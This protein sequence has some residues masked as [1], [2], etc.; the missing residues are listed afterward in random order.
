MNIGIFDPKGNNKNPLN[1]KPYSD[2]YKILSKMWSNLPGYEYGKKFLE[3]L[4]KNDVVL[5]ISATGSGKSVLIPKFCLH[6]MNYKGLTVMTLPKKQITKNTALFGAKTLDTQIGEYVG[7]QYRGENNKSDKTKLLY[8]TDGTIIARIKQ[9]PLISDI[10]ILIIDEAHERATNIDLLLYLVK[11]AIK[12]RKEKK[13]NELKLVIMSATIDET[14]FNRY[15]SNDFNYDYMEM[16][17]KPNYPIKSVFLNESILN[18]KNE[19]IDKGIDIILKLI[20]KINE[21]NLPNGDMIFF[22]PSISECKQVA[23]VIDEKTNDSFSMALYSGFPKHLEI[24]LSN[25]EEYKKLDEKYKRRI[26]IS[27]NVAESSLTLDN[28][29]YVIDSGLEINILYEPNKNI[30]V[31]KKDLISQSNAKQRKGRTGRTIEGYCFH[32]YTEKEFNETH[33]FPLPE[34]NSINLQDICLLF[35]KIQ[36]DIKNKNATINDVKKMFNELIE[37]PQNV[38]IHNGFK[39]CIQRKLIKDE[40]LTKM[41]NLVIDTKLDIFPALTLLYATNIHFHLFDKVYLIICV[42][43]LIKNINDLFYKDIE[44]KEKNK[45]MEKFKKGTYK[46]EHILILELFKYAIQ[47][48]N[49]GIFDEKLLREINKR[50]K[51]K[52]HELYKIY[53]EYNLKLDNVKKNSN[54]KKNIINSFVF[55]FKN[56]TATNKNGKFF[57]NGYICDLK[58]SIFDYK[59]TK[60]IIFSNNL[61]IND[62]KLSICSAI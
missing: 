40:I 60:Q 23:S 54:E 56:N 43:S 17:G 36:T 18:K 32:L 61:L 41:G 42:I 62:L 34:I 31:M 38:F 1:D 20:Q 30:Y 51:Q 11:N 19:Y 57:Y 49:K 59:N 12:L 8:C 13:M 55:G 50:Y 35:M 45:I 46:S 5:I 3:I 2:E 24:F 9:N 53:K 27:T 52:R 58:N 6:Y 37:P 48:L 14:I 16:A 22:L 15:F 29:V 7:F 10:D 25:A 26:F 39:V 21:N 28:I 33:K 4:N 47:N 44:T